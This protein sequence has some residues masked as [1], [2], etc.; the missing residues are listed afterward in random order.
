VCA[1]VCV[2]VCVHVSHGRIYGAQTCGSSLNSIIVRNLT[3]AHVGD[4]V[5]FC[6]LRIA[7]GLCAGRMLVCV[8]A[9]EH[10]LVSV[11]ARAHG[12]VGFVFPTHTTRTHVW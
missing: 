1:C 7:T 8:C 5:A 9:R 10:A 12:G 6:S 3:C 2:C 11:C 4:V